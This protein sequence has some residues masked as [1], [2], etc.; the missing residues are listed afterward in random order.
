MNQLLFAFITGLTNGSI[1]CSA[2][3]GGILASAISKSES[4]FKSTYL[5]LLSKIISHTLFGALLGLLGS[6]LVFS[7]TLQGWLQIFV[8][9]FMIATSLR[10]LNISPVFNLTSLNSPKFLDKWINKIYLKHENL[11]PLILGFSTILIPCGATQAMFILSIGSGSFINGAL[12]MFSFV[13]G[14]TPLFFALGLSLGSIFKYNILAKIASIAILILGLMSINNGQVL[15]G[16]VHTFQNYSYVLTGHND[17]GEKMANIQDGIQI[18]KIKATNSGYNADAKKIKLD[19]PV[20]L[21]IETQN[22]IGCVSTFT[23]P[24]LN[25]HVPLPITGT[26]TVEFTPNKI[27]Q[28]TFSCGMGM[29]T[30]SFEVVK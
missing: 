12:I 25:L 7:L 10:L 18:V 26:K 23:I 13:L 11:R 15:R 20:K 4:K 19:V 17:F 8:G 21:I 30:G 2:T 16:S 3:Q 22:L 14:T 28:L 1:S 5:F 9:I 29:Y 27:G 24:S 6:K